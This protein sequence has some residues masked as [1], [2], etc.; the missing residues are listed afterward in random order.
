MNT[1][2][3]PVISFLASHGGS[4][5]RAIIAAIHAGKLAASVGTVITNNRSSAIYHWCLDNNQTVRHI[6]AK[7]HRGQLE[8][9]EAIATVLKAAD[10]DVVVCSGY[11]KQA[12]PALLEAFKGRIL[13]I[14][15]SL[16]PAHG[17]QGCF[18]DAVHTAVLAAGERQSGATVHI[19]TEQY[20]EGPI[21]MQKTVPVEA[22][23]SVETLRARVQSVEPQ[24]YIDALGLYL[25]N[26]D[27]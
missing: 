13:N 3:K 17:G 4:S 11:M 7:T 15:P 2:K 10:T 27:L 12:G 22:D 6:S 23:D 1:V 18:G 24:L 16:L 19:V 25:Q 20:D 14:H 26:N 9:D 5:A 8:A 21:V